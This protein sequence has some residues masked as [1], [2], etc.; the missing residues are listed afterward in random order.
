MATKRLSLPEK[1]QTGF[2]HLGAEEHS[3]VTQADKAFTPAPNDP[4][5]KLA[6][7]GRTPPELGPDLAYAL[8]DSFAVGIEID[9]FDQIQEMSYMSHVAVATSLTL[10][11]V[12][13]ESRAEKV[14]VFTG[15][16]GF[17][18]RTMRNPFKK[19]GSYEPEFES[20]SG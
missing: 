9:G 16:M 13:G 17:A 11:S 10:I 1:I 20:G 4:L 3:L 2:R 7:G 14:Q 6:T 8:A 19:R 12:N 15:I 5:I 18:K